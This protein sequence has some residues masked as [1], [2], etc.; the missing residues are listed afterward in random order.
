MVETVHGVPVLTATRTALDVAREDGLAAGVAIIDA[1]RHRGVSLAELAAHLERMRHWPHVSIAREALS[2]SDP[3]AESIG[4]SLMR[5]LVAELELGMPMETQFELRDPSGWV[6]C[7]L[8]VGRHVFEFDGSIKY[9]MPQRGGVAT[10]EG[11]RVLLAEKHRQDWVCGF[12]LGM[13]RVVWDDLWGGQRERT[14]I[15]LRREFAATAERFGTDIADLAPYR[16]RRT[17]S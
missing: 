10:T 3:G 14:K 1:V 7:D 11:D 9:R 15:R 12:H 16:V 13:S 6:R 4:E 8:R 17:G 5:L 2:L